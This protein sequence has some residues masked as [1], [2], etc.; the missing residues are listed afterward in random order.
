M[1]E[2]GEMALGMG[3]RQKD[4]NG[5]RGQDVLRIVTALLLLSFAVQSL[6]A[7]S[8]AAGSERV[9]AK[10]YDAPS[11][12]RLGYLVRTSISW[13]LPPGVATGARFRARPGETSVSIEIKDQSGSA[14]DAHVHIDRDGD[15][16]VDLDKDICGSSGKAF[17]IGPEARVEVWPF[18]GT[19]EDGTP[20]IATRGVIEVT[21][22]R[23]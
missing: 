18:V 10:A 4:A 16:H 5:F 20:S 8:L 13:T 7:P 14:V 12:V 6:G 21:F 22:L 9:V 15:G 17:A 2:G 1:S 3:C 23:S 11:G 19:C